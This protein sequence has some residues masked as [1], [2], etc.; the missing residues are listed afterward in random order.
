M[1]IAEHKLRVREKIGYS[2]GDAAANFVW[3]SSFFLPIFYTD[4]FGL[5]AAHA[6]ILLLVVRLSDGV[7]DIIMGTVADRT[8]T[9]QGKFRPWI[10][11]SA[12]F[13][14]LFLC[15]LFTTPDI[16]Y[17]GKFIYAFFVYFGITLIYTANNVPYGALMGVMT[18]GVSERA[19]LS[20]F[21]FAGAFGGGLLVMT[22]LD[23]LV[24]FFGGGNDALGYQ[25]TM[26]PFAILLVV[27][28]VITFLST[29]ERIKPAVSQEG[30][31]KS[32]LGDLFRNLPVIL[33][34]VL[35]ISC[36]II[37]MSQRDWHIG[38]KVA[39]VA[40][41]FAMFYVTYILRAGIISKPDAEK[42]RTQRDLSDL[43]T[44]KPWFILLIVGVLFGIFTVIRPSAAGFYFKYFIDAPDFVAFSLSFTLGDKPINFQVDSPVAAYFFI[45]LIASFFA[46]IMTGFLTDKFNKRTLFAIAFGG[47]AV[48][49]AAVYFVDRDQLGLMFTLAAIAEVFAGMMP[50][51]FYGMLGDTA[52]YSEW[53]NNRRSTGLVYSAGT[54]I[55]KT[56]HGLA[57][58]VVMMV[59]AMYGYNAEIAETIA[60]SISGMV[61]LMSFIPALFCVV[62]LAVIFSYPLT[63]E[64]MAE[65]ER[66][67]AERRK[68]SA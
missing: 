34:P 18:P 12:P 8:N 10:L 30:S 41:C 44:N 15:L 43:L 1:S 2:L 16:S 55:N 42:T 28:N 63:N 29:K 37:A 53:K 66:D 7:T 45:T 14:G 24:K 48:F 68:Q 5:T 57:G 65:I 61:L 60:Q 46:A 50:V 54:F 64:R 17:T 39:A 67:L 56:G 58:A 47:A 31:L 20:A 19:S 51:L 6:A 11:W 36:L 23:P 40:F 26:I 21:R 52:D 13:L 33:M 9:R 59:L 4:T 25:Q 62:G 22:T 49:S 3:R 35:G 32:E 27:F 38:I